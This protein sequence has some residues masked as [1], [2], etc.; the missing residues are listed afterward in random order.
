MFHIVAAARSREAPRGALNS[1][2]G[3]AGQR[4][5]AGAWQNLY[6]E[7]SLVA[8]HL[9]SGSRCSECRKVTKNLID[10]CHH[11][12]VKTTLTPSPASKR[13]LSLG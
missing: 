4:S 8:C 7:R 6:P 1:S 9:V 10:I 12:F 2:E 13:Y 11:S 5:I 3:N